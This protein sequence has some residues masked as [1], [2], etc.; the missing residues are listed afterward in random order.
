M[1]KAIKAKKRK[2]PKYTDRDLIRA[3]FNALM[4]TMDRMDRLTEMESVLYSIQ[5]SVD[6]LS[7]GATRPAEVAAS[8]EQTIVAVTHARRLIEEKKALGE[9]IAALENQAR[10]CHWCREYV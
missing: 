3:T 10:N 7:E 2:E 6:Q 4:V 8:R 1:K 9:R 5:Q